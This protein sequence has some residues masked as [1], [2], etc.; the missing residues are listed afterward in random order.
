MSHVLKIARSVIQALKKTGLLGLGLGSIV[1]LIVILDFF[2]L[3][4]SLRLWLDEISTDESLKQAALWLPDYQRIKRNEIDCIN[5][6][7]SGLTYNTQTKTWF[8]IVDKPA[9][10]LEFNDSGHCLRKH[11]LAGLKD[12]E[13]IVWIKGLQF[14]VAEE[15][16]R[17]LS[18]ITLKQDVDSAVEIKT[19]IKL[20]ALGKENNKGFEA[21]A[22]IPSTQTVL[23]AKERGSRK[24]FALDNLL[25]EKSQPL[26]IQKRSELLPSKYLMP[27]IS[28]MH[29]EKTSGNF[30]LLSDRSR[31][32]AEVSPEGKL[33]SHIKFKSQFH[34]FAKKLNQA[35]GVASN[36]EGDIAIVA[37]PN[38]LVI[39]Q[40]TKP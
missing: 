8:A 7:V 4:Y 30:L 38:I 28:G 20:E 36:E 32:L 15:R 37:E 16:R 14:I 22:F 29:Y 19:L 39:M 18:L 34:G 31:R 2:D 25:A 6:G 33:I 23:I 3:D 11:V 9:T 27:D 10:L 5:S 26:I 21:L 24:L 40:K 1:M 17:A 35:E 13:A 12:V